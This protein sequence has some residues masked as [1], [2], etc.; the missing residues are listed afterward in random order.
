MDFPMTDVTCG[1]K[2]E[3]GRVRDPDY[4]SGNI[5]NKS[6]GISWISNNITEMY[7]ICNHKHKDTVIHNFLLM[8]KNVQKL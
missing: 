1:I 3:V 4:E 6:T 2:P 7:H 8:S 5:I